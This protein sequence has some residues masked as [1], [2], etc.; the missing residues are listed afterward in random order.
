MGIC[1][2]DYS[3]CIANLACSVLK[4]YGITPPNDTLAEAD[5]LLQKQYRNVVIL[6]LDGMGMNILRKHLQPD[7]F[8]RRNLRFEYLSTF[9]PTT[10]AATTAVTSG[11][12]PNQSAWLG[13]VGYFP[14]LNRNVVYFLN[15]D[16]DTKEKIE[17]IHAAFTYLPYEMITDRIR[18][19]GAEGTPR[20]RTMSRSLRS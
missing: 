16:N 11:L 1:Y 20:G 17:G 3:R 15:K 9:P 5:A 6:L 2:P 7:G 13:W 4:H 8:L 14:E 18:Q 12:F 10:V 19:T